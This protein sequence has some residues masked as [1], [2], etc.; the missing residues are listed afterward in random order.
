MTTETHLDSLAIC[1]MICTNIGVGRKFCSI[2][3]CLFLSLGA[4]RFWIC[5]YEIGYGRT[6]LLMFPYTPSLS[7]LPTCCL[8]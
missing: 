2:L 3:F 6:C 8:G 4:G 5:Y 7:Y 1:S